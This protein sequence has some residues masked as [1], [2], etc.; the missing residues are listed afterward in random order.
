MSCELN[1]ECTTNMYRA[2]KHHIHGALG[3]IRTQQI[4]QL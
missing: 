1:N 3:T 2:L 4:N